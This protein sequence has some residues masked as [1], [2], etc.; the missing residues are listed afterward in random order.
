MKT[1]EQEQRYRT[2][3]KTYGKQ[4]EGKADAESV[5]A[6]LKKNYTLSTGDE[7]LLQEI[8]LEVQKESR[9]SEAFLQGFLG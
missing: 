5:I 3:K 8:G 7:E 1:F 9:L 4:F 2:L 6:E